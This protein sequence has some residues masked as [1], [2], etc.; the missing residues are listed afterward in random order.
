MCLARPRHSAAG[1]LRHS[2]DARSRGYLLNTLPGVVTGSSVIRWRWAA[3][4][5][6]LLP[7]GGPGG[8]GRGQRHLGWPWMGHMG[9]PST[10]AAA[11]ALPLPPPSPAPSS[12][13]GESGHQLTSRGSTV[14]SAMQ[15]SGDSNL[16]AGLGGPFPP[17]TES[18]GPQ[19]WPHSCRG[20]MRASGHLICAEGCPGRLGRGAHPGQAHTW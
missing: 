6:W 14:S 4:R 20:H 11:C 10:V 18:Q 15:A 12:A 13:F 17:P 1:S 8:W 2:L 19:Q 5:G 9:L 3:C 7:D 16:R